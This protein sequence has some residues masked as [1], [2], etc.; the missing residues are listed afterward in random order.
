MVNTNQSGRGGVET[1]TFSNRNTCCVLL[2]ADQKVNSS[3]GYSLWEFE[4]YGSGAISTADLE[5]INETTN[6]KLPDPVVLPEHLQ[7]E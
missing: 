3:W 7:P 1:R 2:I 5:S 6:R 4:V